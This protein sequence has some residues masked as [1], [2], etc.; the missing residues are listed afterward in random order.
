MSVPARDDGAMKPLDRVAREVL[1]DSPLTSGPYFTF[2]YI[3]AT[4]E[5]FGLSTFILFILGNGRLECVAFWIFV[6]GVLLSPLIRFVCNML[7]FLRTN[8]KEERTSYVNYWKES[9]GQ[10]I[11]TLA[12]PKCLV[13]VVSMLQKVAQDATNTSP[14]FMVLNA[15]C[16][17]IFLCLITVGWLL[18]TGM[19]ILVFLVLVFPGHPIAVLFSRITKK[20]LPEW[21]QRYIFLYNLLAAER[22][23]QFKEQLGLTSTSKSVA[24]LANE[25]GLSLWTGYVVTNYFQ[26]ALGALSISRF[27]EITD[28][29]KL[30]GFYESLKKGNL[31]GGGIRHIIVKPPK[32]EHQEHCLAKC[33]ADNLMLNTDKLGEL[34]ATGLQFYTVGSYY[35]QGSC[36]SWFRASLSSSEL[37]T[38][39]ILFAALRRQ[40]LFVSHRWDSTGTWNG[41]DS[42]QLRE[43]FEHMALPRSGHK[44]EYFWM[45]GLSVPQEH[46]ENNENASLTM[47]V[48]SH[49]ATL[50]QRCGRF[51]I[52]DRVK[53]AVEVRDQDRV[54]AGDYYDHRTW[55]QFELY[56]ARNLKPVTTQT[57]NVRDQDQ[58][59]VNVDADHAFIQRLMTSSAF[60]MEDKLFILQTIFFATPTAYS[61]S[62]YR[63]MFMV[64]ECFYR[65]VV[66]FRSRRFKAVSA[67]KIVG[68]N[69]ITTYLRGL[70]ETME[71]GISQAD[72]IP[73][74]RSSFLSQDVRNILDGASMLVDGMGYSK[75]FTA[76][77][78]VSMPFVYAID[79]H[80]T[81][82]PSVSEWCPACTL[83]LAVFGLSA[84]AI[85]TV[86]LEK[87]E[88]HV[89]L[90]HCPDV[91]DQ[92]AFKEFQIQME[93]SE[94]AKAKE[95]ILRLPW[96]EFPIV[97]VFDDEVDPEELQSSGSTTKG[98]QLRRTAM[99]TDSTSRWIMLLTIL[100]WLPVA[101]LWMHFFLVLPVADLVSLEGVGINASCSITSGGCWHRP[102]T[103]S[104]FGGRHAAW[105]CEVNVT[106]G[107][108]PGDGWPLAAHYAGSDIP[109]GA[110]WVATAEQYGTANGLVGL[111][112]AAPLRAPSG[113]ALPASAPLLPGERV[114]CAYRPAA[115]A[116]CGGAPLGL[117]AE[118]SL[119]EGVPGA[120]GTAAA[121]ARWVAWGALP[122]VVLLYLV[123]FDLPPS[124]CF[125]GGRRRKKQCRPGKEAGPESLGAAQVAPSLPS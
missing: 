24:L 81:P 94:I 37:M 45:D 78:L 111:G 28:S 125:G 14:F 23:L 10:S 90:E 83:Y 101:A 66:Y 102:H 76:K 59:A 5:Q 51:L 31:A 73:A 82:S 56:L 84:K 25:L 2:E 113:A 91:M 119:G 48:I 22:S 44:L 52:I 88:F 50:V 75:V 27:E 63:P 60:K 89:I 103:Y 117:C 1:H 122:A 13:G 55:C 57:H 46:S 7:F 71:T 120:L 29:E 32:R 80:P 41:R 16:L 6:F 64:F 21:Y 36:L 123:T 108:A 99:F 8:S 39:E 35:K 112:R 109:W 121:A 106:L 70:A 15:A 97:D 17:P 67:S 79:I 65:F 85:C 107:A 62:T 43:V 116:V 87:R 53:N 61:D 40:T 110:S 3:H 20:D 11:F 30:K 33:A 42:W 98:F 72:L 38:S 114:R 96:S 105:T 115:A 124:S 104:V 92:A 58:A 93:D 18:E 26:F 86:H 19:G 47:L 95:D 34:R 74:T 9:G 77:E 100:F 49:L 118:V 69:L 4:L 12:T 68:L 54:D